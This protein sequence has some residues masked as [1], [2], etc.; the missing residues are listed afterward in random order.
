MNDFLR[1]N[2][3]KNKNEISVQALA[4]IGDAV[5]ELMI[6]T[7]LCA[8]GTTTAKELHKKTVKYVCAKSQALAIERILPFL[9]DDEIAVYKRGRNAYAGAVPKGATFGEYHAATGF[10]A[11]FGYLYLNGENE[12]LNELFVIISS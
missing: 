1:P 12:R 9:N 10:E 4:H 11:L 8:D 7:L 2:N 6:R 5:Y 3:I